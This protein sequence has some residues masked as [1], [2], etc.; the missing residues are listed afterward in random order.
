MKQKARTNRWIMIAVAWGVINLWLLPYPAV[1]APPAASAK[2]NAV[3]TVATV[4]PI[5]EVWTRSITASGGIYP[6]QEALVASELSGLSIVSLTVDIGSAVKKGQELARLEADSVQAALAQAQANLQQAQAGYA[7]AQSNANRARDMK[8]GML[9]E[10]QQVQYQIA[11]QSAQ[12]A[13]N[14]AKA[15]VESQ[16]IRL[17]QTRILAVDDGIITSRSAALGMVVQTGS[18]LFRLIRQ[19]RLEWRA[20]LT[21][22]Q[23]AQVKVGQTAQLQLSNGQTVSGQVRLLAPTL[24]PQTRKGLAYID[25]PSVPQLQ[26]GLFAQGELQLDTTPALTIPAAALVLRDGYQYVFVVQADSRVTRRK[27]TTG[28]WQGERV[29][30]LQGL[31]P[32]TAI[33]A[34]GGAFLNEG[35]GVRVASPTVGLVP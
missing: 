14:A 15:M 17:R 11:E 5:T 4:V 1:A 8:Q 30:V 12:A 24:D 16:A 20:E 27:V 22:A 7:E 13:V 18:E 33:V 21:A 35:D 32:G 26:A 29:E 34:S 3:L 9:S 31:E 10:Q 28:R 25:L 19:N 6:W 23:R 2:T